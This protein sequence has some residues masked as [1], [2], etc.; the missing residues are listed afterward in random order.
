[1][2]KNITN[3]TIPLKINGEFIMIQPGQEIDVSE[4]V[5]NNTIGLEIIEN[6]VEEKPI[7]TDSKKKSKKTKK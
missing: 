2:Y 6:T 5:A 1:M 4:G 7:N 3:K